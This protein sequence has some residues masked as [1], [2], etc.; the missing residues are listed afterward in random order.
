MLRLRH[1]PPQSQCSR[2]SVDKGDMRTCHHHHAQ[3]ASRSQQRVWGCTGLFLDFL[4]PSPRDVTYGATQPCY[5]VCPRPTSSDCA[6][7]SGMERCRR[8]P[9]HQLHVRHP[10]QK[11][12]T[13]RLSEV[14][15]ITWPVEAVRVAGLENIV[16]H[17]SIPAPYANQARVV[18]LGQLLNLRQ[19]RKKSRG[20]VAT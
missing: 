20:Y 12:C 5:G 9:K 7:G 13:C 11:P 4:P 10:L 16:L 18:G 6:V 3:A 8:W 1:S 15:H 2:G 19:H 17:L 14:A